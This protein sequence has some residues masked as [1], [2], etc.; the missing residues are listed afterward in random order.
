MA[1]INFETEDI[2]LEFRMAAHR[3]SNELLDEDFVN[4]F[5]F[6]H[7]LY[8]AEIFDRLIEELNKL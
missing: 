7:N 4:N 2:I 5:M 1:T 8:G 6:H 3:E